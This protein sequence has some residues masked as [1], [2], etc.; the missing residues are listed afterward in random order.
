MVQTPLHVATGYN[1]V[2]I[3]KFLLS[4]P[5]PEKVELEAKNMVREEIYELQLH[6]L[7]ELTGLGHSCN[8]LL[9]SF[10]G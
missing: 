10:W 6:F 2:E 1:N 5:G 7:L 3:L 4:W 8:F 9:S